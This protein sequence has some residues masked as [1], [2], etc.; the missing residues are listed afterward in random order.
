A[1]ILAAKDP[2]AV[3]E[4]NETSILSKAGGITSATGIDDVQAKVAKNTDLFNKFGFESIPT[5]VGLHAQ[6]G[7]LVKKEGSMPTPELAAF[8]GLAQPAQ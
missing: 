8:L 1:T 3:M 5:V 7:L 2:A 4:E 6:T